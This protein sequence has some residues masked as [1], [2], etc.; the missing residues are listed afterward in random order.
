MSEL[1][2]HLKAVREEKKISLEDIQQTTKIQKRYLRAI[3]EGQYDTL[4]GIFYARAFVKTYAEAIGL[5]PEP[6]FDQYEN[7]LPN[8]TQEVIELPSRSDRSKSLAIPRKQRKRNSLFPALLGIAVLV[9]VVYA[10]W[11]LAQSEGWD[12]A[13]NK[14]ISPDEHEN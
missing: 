13:G 2:Q 8:P 1:G 7:E 11:L 5:D 6:L 4:P 12:G 10:V 14:P 9:V 3:E